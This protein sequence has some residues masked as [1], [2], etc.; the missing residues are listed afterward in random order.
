MAWYKCKVIF[1]EKTNEDGERREDVKEQYAVEAVSVTDAATIIQEHLEGFN[2]SLE[3]VTKMQIK[4]AFLQ[5][6]VNGFRPD[7]YP[8]FIA[9]LALTTTDDYGIEKKQNFRYMIEER[10]FEGTY[11]RL[12][13][14]MK[15][16]VSDIEIIS[17]SLSTI[18]E[19]IEAEKK[20]A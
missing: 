6:T 5:A 14:E 11:L 12:K 13:D 19:A 20:E 8:I 2:F 18:V 9:K 4:E 1:A 10:T 17:I 15:G 16:S 3:E 7:G